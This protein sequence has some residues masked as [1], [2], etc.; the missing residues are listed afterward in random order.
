MARP[1]V[2][3]ARQKMFRVID[4]YSGVLTQTIAK[5][6]DHVNLKTPGNTRYGKR[7][8]AYPYFADET[9]RDSRFSI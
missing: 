3:L 4:L 1:C 7:L 2:C 8:S 5:I 6:N 9:L